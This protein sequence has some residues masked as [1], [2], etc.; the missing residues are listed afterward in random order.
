MGG[1]RMV[2][3]DDEYDD[4]FPEREAGQVSCQYCGSRAVRWQDTPNGWRLYDIRGGEHS[5]GTVSFDPIDE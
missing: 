1:L 2:I 5:C 3:F 4:Y